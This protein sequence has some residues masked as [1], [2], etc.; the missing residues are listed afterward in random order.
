MGKQDITSEYECEVRHLVRGRK[1]FRAKLDNLGLELQYKY[2]ETD[3][4]YKPANKD[5]DPM[6]QS[7]RIR[8]WEDKKYPTTIYISKH[9]IENY[10]GLSFKKSVYPAGKIAL[11]QGELAE[12]R[13]ILRDMGLGEWIEIKK[14]G[15]FWK[16]KNGEFKVGLE[17]IHQLGIY[18][19]IEVSSPQVAY[20]YEKLS[21][22]L[23]DLKISFDEVSGLPISQIYLGNHC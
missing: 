19:E 6:T 14:K 23:N 3:Y 13:E 9:T 2:S 16:T 21:K 22:I 8:H 1:S 12:C 7:I 10:N 5:F 20:A 11:F 17:Q 15:E 18:A 4:Y